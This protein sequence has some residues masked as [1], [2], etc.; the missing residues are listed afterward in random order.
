MNSQQVILDSRL[1]HVR[2]LKTELARL[3]SEN[4]SL[5]TENEELVSHMDL[6]ILAAEDV[7]DLGEN[8]RLIIWDGWNMILG[9]DNEA[10]DPTE[11]IAI[12]KRQL[13]ENPTD[14]IWIVFDGPRENSI[15]DGRLRV[16]YTGG[17]GQHRADRL[18]CDFLRMARFRGDLSRIEV[19]TKD[20]D[21]LREVG[22][23]VR[24]HG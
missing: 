4:N 8:G 13:A 12:A 20:K 11:L 2:E 14:R 6:A 24:K 21:F 10:H 7:K 17:A 23:I 1:T 15:V 9:A 18:I 16:S 5:R 19:K 22:R 3:R